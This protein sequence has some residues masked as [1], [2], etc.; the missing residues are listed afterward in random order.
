MRARGRFVV[1]GQPA[2]PRNRNAQ[3]GSQFGRRGQHRQHVFAKLFDVRPPVGQSPRHAATQ[4]DDIGP[5]A[6]RDAFGMQVPSLG[7]FLLLLLLQ[8]FVLRLRAIYGGIGHLRGM[9]QVGA[10]LVHLGTDLVDVFQL[11]G[12]KQTPR[13]HRPIDEIGASVLLGRNQV[14]TAEPRTRPQCRAGTRRRL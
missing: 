10:D 12:R 14:A 5:L 3:R 8:R 2:E 13:D 9:R 6:M 11:L 7:G 1:K 4:E